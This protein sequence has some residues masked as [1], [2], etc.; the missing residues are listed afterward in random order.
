MAAAKDVEK[1][2]SFHRTR[3]QTFEKAWEEFKYKLEQH[4]QLCIFFRDMHLINKQIEELNSQLASIRQSYGESLPSA[5]YTSQAFQQFEKTIEAEMD[6][7]LHAAQAEAEAAKAAAAAAQQ[8]A[9]AA[10]AAAKAIPPKPQ[11]RPP[12]FVKQL[13]DAEVSEGIKFTFECEVDGE[14]MPQ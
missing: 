1:V 9:K 5:L 6:A 8:A 7:V 2:S 13:A 4:N 12:R 11:Q 10:E 3:K 14:P